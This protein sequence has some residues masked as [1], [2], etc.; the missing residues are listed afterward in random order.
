MPTPTRTRRLARDHF[1]AL[2]AR[3]LRTPIGTDLVLHERPDPEAVRLDGRRLAAVVREAAER[4]R[5]PLAIPLM[6]LRLEKADLVRRL[7]PD[8]GE[9]DTFHFEAPPS[10]ADLD[11]ARE[12]DDAA[13]LAVHRAQ[14]DAIAEL[15]SRPGLLPFGISVGP[16][17]LM[18]K[19]LADP[20]G[21]VALAGRGASGADEPLVATA[22]RALVLAEL[23][24]RRSLRAQAG[25][26][27]AA[28]I[29]CEP[30]A[31]ALFVSPRQMAS[32]SPVF[33]RFV[34]EPLVRLK[35]QLDDLGVDLLLHDCGDP[36]TG[37]VEALASRVHP[38]VL[39]LGSSRR[40]WEDAAVVPRDVVLFG[41]LPTK[42]FHSD[43]TL[44]LE[45]VRA[46]TRELVLKMRE[47]AH[48]F[49]LGSECDVLHVEEAA[50]T[51]RRKVEAMLTEAA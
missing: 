35:A 13:F 34:L 27:A 41:N 2:A 46:K 18:T 10:E 38:A 29:V 19:L 44:P 28:A 43:E 49:I 37:M 16:F 15:A 14:C 25:A 9:A 17:S 23:A 20:I 31:S 24:V 3:G 39:S 47:T 42:H 7:R 48:P 45:A 30:A 26:G 22:E 12:T 1:R 36:T 6:D 51:I 8:V 50:A 33:G 21:A 4:Y 32:G 5:T 11:R 40:L